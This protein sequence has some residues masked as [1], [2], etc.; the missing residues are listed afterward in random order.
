MPKKLPASGV[1]TKVILPSGISR[2]G[3]W[4]TWSES[5]LPSRRLTRSK[6]TPA[7]TRLLGVRTRNLRQVK[8]KDPLIERVLKLL[9]REAQ[10][11]TLS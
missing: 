1:V 11:T 3:R 10:S 2:S 9:K 8:C 4:P 6:G 5:A 7:L